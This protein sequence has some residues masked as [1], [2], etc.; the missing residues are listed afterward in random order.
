MRTD[1]AGPSL[2]LIESCLL[3]VRVVE[4]QQLIVLSASAL[5]LPMLLYL[6]ETNLLPYCLHLTVHS[7]FALL[8]VV[9]WHLLLPMTGLEVGPM[10]WRPCDVGVGEKYAVEQVVPGLAQVVMLRLSCLEPLLLRQWTVILDP[11]T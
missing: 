3:M 9:V 5:G 8:V 10:M 1:L 11:P 7:E 2:L 4:V 6:S